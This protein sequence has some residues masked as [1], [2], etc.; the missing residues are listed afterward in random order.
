MKQDESTGTLFKIS[1]SVR[2]IMLKDQSC[3]MYREFLERS[4]IEEKKKEKEK[5]DIINMQKMR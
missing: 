4:K 1:D 3:D 5:T 2:S